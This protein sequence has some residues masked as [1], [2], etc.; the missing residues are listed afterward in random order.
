MGTG[1]K[2]AQPT[3][4]TI[5]QTN[6]PAY[7]QPY[8]TDMLKRG[9]AVSNQQYTPYEGQRIAGFNQA[10]DAAH[11]GIAGLQNPW[12]FGSASDMALQ[13]GMGSLAAGQYDPA[14]FNAMMVNPGQATT[15]SFTDPG[16]MGQYMSPYMQNVLDVQKQA[17]LRDAQ[18]SQLAQNLGASR[19]GTYGG[20]RQLL[21]TTERERNLLDQMGQ[22]QATGMQSAYDAAQRG[23]ESDQARGLQAQG[24][25]MQY[26]LQGQ[27]ANQQAQ[28]EAQRLAE[29]SRQFGGTLG[30][31][32]Y[33]QALQGADI[34]GG[35]GSTQQQGDLQRL[36]AQ[37]AVGQE[38]QG[39]EQQ[40]LDTAYADFLRQRDYPMEML[41]YYSN[42]IQGTPM[43]MGSTQTTYAQPPSTMAQ[44]GGLGLAGLGLYNMTK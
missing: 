41:G 19:T 1:A 44:V 12:Q 2:Q 10:Q 31:Q 17:A 35:L 39:L 4:Q 15:G 5:T 16:V 24:M 27:M 6:L 29:Q 3:N 38:Q 9:Q 18:Q 42:L 43:S 14:Q 11:A 30:L 21:A 13:G 28:L 8:V 23:Y 32:G 26:G 36:Q 25:N 40:R 20:A 7:A 33:S 34:L 37:S 22:I